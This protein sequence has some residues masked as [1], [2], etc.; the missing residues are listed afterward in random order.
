M[1]DILLRNG[2]IVDGSGNPWFMGDVAICDGQVAAIGFVPPGAEAR[3]ELHLDG[4]VICPGFVD[5]HSHSDLSILANPLANAKVEQGVTTENL[6]LDSYS[7]APIREADKADWA[8]LLSGLAGKMDVAWNWHSFADYLDAIDAARPSVNASSYVGLGTVRN[9][10]MGMVDTPPS[11]AQLATMRELVTE[12]MDQGARG[13]S[14]GLIYTPNKYQSTEELV[15]LVRVAAAYQG[16]FDV[17]MRNEA[18]HMDEALDEV[19]HIGRETGVRVLVTHF[20]CRG[21]NNWGRAEAMLEK[22]DKARREGVDVTIAQYPYTA[23]ST[24]MHVVIPPWYHKRGMSGMLQAL[25]DEREQIRKDLLITE[26]WE[27]FSQVMGWENI[28]VSSVASTRNAWCEGQS[29][30]EI[31]NARHVDPVDAVCDLL[32]EE[33]LAVG[34]IGFG[35]SEQD[36][37]TIM[38]HPA[39]CVITDSLMSGQKPHPRSYASYPR[40]LARYVRETAVLTLEEA[41]RKMSYAGAQRLRLPRKGLLVPGWDADIVVFDEQN[42]LDCNSF[43]TP[44][45]PPQGIEHVLVNGEFV[46]RET[47]HTG[48]RPG[49]T[50]R[51]R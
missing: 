35:M 16:V 11:P 19:I 1:F 36:V 33:E 39:M 8:V 20:K 30:V 38:R 17:H 3:E 15:E 6:G 45:V 7:L 10:V 46:V 4:K 5:S 41:I 25:R 42:V 2:K 44:R 48:A 13:V 37:L 51:S 47:R 21:R 31:A 40:L 27:N 22:V 24:L 26:G 9:H 18:D 14:A 29:L 28:Y 49:K 32:Y 43:D 12:A 50:I 23:N 34:L